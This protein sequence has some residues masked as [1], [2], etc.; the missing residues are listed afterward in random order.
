M[1]PIFSIW[2][3]IRFASATHQTVDRLCQWVKLEIRR[4]QVAAR[5]R[6]HLACALER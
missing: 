1:A 4:M 2:R 6:A 5:D 3:R